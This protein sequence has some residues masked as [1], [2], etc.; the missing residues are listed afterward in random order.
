LLLNQS[1]HDLPML[2]STRLHVGAA[3]NFQL[4][5]AG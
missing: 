1:H 5:S 4:S 3:V 2:D